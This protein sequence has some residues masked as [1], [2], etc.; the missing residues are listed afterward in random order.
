MSTLESRLREALHDGASSVDESPDLFARVELSV[1]DD[2]RLRRAASAA[3]SPS[4]GCIVGAI[5]A[6]IV[7]RHRDQTRRVCSWTGGSSS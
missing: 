3:S 1:H 6:V 4:L 7:R 5:A 2:Q